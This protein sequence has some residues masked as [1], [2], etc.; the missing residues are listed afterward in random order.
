[1][2]RVGHIN[3]FRLKKDFEGDLGHGVPELNHLPV[4]VRIYTNDYL[5]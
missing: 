5:Y 2:I 1:M 3:I 4:N